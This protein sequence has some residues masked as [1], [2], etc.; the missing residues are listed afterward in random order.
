MR[1][2]QGKHRA[3]HTYIEFPFGDTEQRSEP[4][5][6]TEDGRATNIATEVP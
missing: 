3:G 2:P 5:G 1:P 6:I 4:R